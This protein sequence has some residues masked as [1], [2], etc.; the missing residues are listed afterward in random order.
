MNALHLVEE[1]TTIKTASGV[2]IHIKK[3]I[4]Q[5]EMKFRNAAAFQTRPQFGKRADTFL[6]FQHTTPHEP[7]EWPMHFSAEGTPYL[8]HVVACPGDWVVLNET[9]G[10]TSIVSKEKF[11]TTFEPVRKPYQANRPLPAIRHTPAMLL[12]A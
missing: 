9:S 6:A 11:E 2:S 5:M 8:P 3:R 4:S 1:S 10:E 7:L 12:A